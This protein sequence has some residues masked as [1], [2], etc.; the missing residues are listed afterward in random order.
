M[1]NYSKTDQRFW[2]DTVFRHT[3]MA[4][5]KTYV[6]S[7]YSVRI[8]HKGRRAMFALG[9]S[10]RAAAAARA[11]DIYIYLSANDWE[12]TLT[13]FKS[14]TPDVEGSII[15]VGDFIREIKARSPK[16]DLTLNGY[17]RCL[18]R[19]A[20]NT[21][22]IA[23]GAEKYDYQ[24]GGR[25]KWM[26]QVDAI[27]IQ[28]LTPT[29]VHQW[30]INFLNQVDSN[31]AKQRAARITVN[32]ILRQARSLFS[33]KRLQTI[34]ATH[35]QSPFEGVALEPKQSMRYQSNFNIEE[36][37]ENAMAELNQEELKVFLLASMAGLRRNEIDK[38]PWT[39]FNWE[40][41]T[42]RIEV[43]EH[44]N[45]KS[46]HSIGEVD[47]EPELLALFRQLKAN[48]VGPLVIYSSVQPRPN[49]EYPH[50]RCNRI[51]A[52]LSTW[53]RA[54]GVSGHSPLHTLR[55]EYGSQVCHQFGIYAAS[56]A[57]RHADIGITAQ[58]YLDKK[59][60]ITVGFGKHLLPRMDSN[61]E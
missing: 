54:K 57:L 25:Q 36:L 8:Q 42:L 35:L 23:S 51:F 5:G 49:A 45:A 44:F 34:N 10:N 19:I 50:Y 27:K 15:T 31:P 22:N 32:S 21:F 59:T 24:T 41:G 7:D 12:K 56:R 16:R 6:D 55:K 58:H 1:A 13:K 37:I 30:K 3:R 14:K 53:L 17:I 38:L 28:N 18:R 52:R 11:R 2:Q 39:A 26:E 46:E 40:K 20:S 9:T 29:L 43:T 60:R 61:H 4:S 47:L 48:A 33:S